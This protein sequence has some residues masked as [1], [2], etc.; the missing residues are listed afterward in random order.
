[1][2]K[3]QSVEHDHFI[4]VV[5]RKRQFDARQHKK[6][7]LGAKRAK[8]LAAMN[9]ENADQT[10]P[11]TDTISSHIRFPLSSISL[12][13]PS[14]SITDRNTKHKTNRVNLG[15]RFDNE[16]M[17]GA[18][19]SSSHT[20]NPDS[21][22]N[23]LF[24]DDSEDDAGSSN[25]SDAC[26]S[27]SNYSMDEHDVGF[28]T[29]IEEIDVQSSG[30]YYDLGDPSFECQQCGA[31]M[32]YMERKN[33]FRHCANPKFSMCCGE[34]KVQIPLLR[35][36]SPVLQ[37]LLFDQN[38]SESKLFQQ[39]IRLYNMMFAFNSP[40]AKMDNKFNNGRGPPNYHIQ[41]QSCHR[42]GSM[43]P[44]LGEKAHFSQLYIFDTE[45]EVQNIIDVFRR[46]SGVDINI[47]ENLSSMLYEHNVHAQSFKMA[48]DRLSEGNVAD[49]KLRLISE[50]QNDGRI[51][52]Q[53]TVSEV[54]ALIVGDVDTAE[55]GIL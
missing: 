33:K 7:V 20:P 18:T 23:E 30:E 37:S 36:P 17:R 2:E 19:T 24:Q 34:G 49:L 54:V 13:I 41:G 8:R 16:F 53:P 28:D 11:P 29:D 3:K 55:K 43:L 5:R 47:V 32:W 40:G 1:M 52:N 38:K 12:N 44:L 4:N 10:Q 50:R 27:I 21:N 35:E 48:R 45:H 46:R 26:S 39:Q 15:R 51:Y 25:S 42:I 9:K 31:N 14:S 6:R 22:I